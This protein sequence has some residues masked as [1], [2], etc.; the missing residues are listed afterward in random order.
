MLSLPK[1]KYMCYP[2]ARFSAEEEKYNKCVNIFS[3]TK[4]LFWCKEM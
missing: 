1:Q 2:S 4:S 3:Y